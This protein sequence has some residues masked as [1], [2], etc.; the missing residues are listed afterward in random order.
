MSLFGYYA[1][2]SFINQLKKLFNTWVLIFILVCGLMGGIIG[3]GAGSLTASY[4]QEHYEEMEEETYEEEEE[5]EIELPIEGKDIFELAVGALVLVYFVYKALTA[6]E[7]A[8]KIFLPGDTVL[9][10]GSP[11][12]PQAVLFFRLAAQMGTL[13]LVSIYMMFQ[14]PNLVLNLGLTMGSA[15]FAAAD[16]FFALLLGL[17]LSTL[18]YLLSSCHPFVRKHLDKM[19]YGLLAAAALGFFI[20]RK[21]SGLPLIEALPAYF[22]SRISRL[23]PLWGWV[24][25]IPA[26]ANEGNY[27]AAALM[28]LLSCLLGVFMIYLIRRLP[29]DFY[30]D[31][32]AKSAETAKLRE[33][34][35]EGI[36]VVNAS[37][38]KNRDVV[39]DGFRTGFGA[40]VFFFK[41]LY[42][43]WRFARLHYFTSTT[44]TYLAAGVGTAL[45]T[46]FIADSSSFAPVTYLLGVLVFFRS[47][48]NPLGED[49]KMEFFRS[50]PESSA[51]KIFYSILGG[52]VNC[53]LDLL[54]GMLLAGLLLS[55]GPLEVAGSLLFVVT[56]DFFSTMIGT[57]ID[58]S[59]P[60]NAGKMVKQYVQIFFL[61]FGLLPDV[62]CIAVLT[63][64][65]HGALGLVLASFVNVLLGLAF[66]VVT[67]R[68]LEP[69][70]RR[71]LPPLSFPDAE[72]LKAAKRVFSRCGLALFVFLGASTLGQLLSG[73]SLTLLVDF[74]LLSG[75]EGWAFWIFNMLPIYLIGVPAGWLVFR[76]IPK[77]SPKG[78]TRPAGLLFKAFFV[79]FF[80]MYAGNYLG[81]FAVNLLEKVTGAEGRNTV[82]LLADQGALLPRF[83]FFVIMAPVFEE[84]VFRKFLIDRLRPYGEKLAILLSGLLFGLFHGNL[85]QFFYAAFLGGIFAYVYLRT[86][87]LRNT[88]LLHML[89]NFNG[90]IL[91]VELAKKLLAG[92]ELDELMEF[93][94]IPAGPLVYIGYLMLVLGIAAVGGVFFFSGLSRLVFVRQEKELPL[95]CG[96]P[97]AI[98]NFGMC[99][100][101]LASLA[102]FVS[103]YLL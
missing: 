10:F 13:L 28:A 26:Y 2:H 72:A 86:G 83:V 77:S 12:T 100:F 74:G 92:V 35:Q 37:S 19:V 38:A 85:N 68:L 64:K 48:G 52:G 99:L 103:G 55:A 65:G 16:W 98:K 18:L 62:A 15:L 50:I 101:I 45:V 24:K 61:Y 102:L 94:K 89:V 11:M 40:N 60:V 1:V 17:I 81:I 80:F 93:S 63:V 58:L 9:L 90:G 67:P 8:S 39:R 73:I 96:V 46:R 79:S 44:F 84:L 47:L 33:K 82:E 23:I 6:S 88:I 78:D 54:P 3:F 21:V 29:V 49:T 30:E 75:E 22:N 31:A 27:A 43:R 7:N 25:A 71:P 70:C 53:L 87:K 36:S 56:I 91:S 57:F 69:V 34:A 59:V 20:F 14:I 95:S 97:A 41:A 51:S 4:E 32:A 42:N 76:R 66:F 5:E